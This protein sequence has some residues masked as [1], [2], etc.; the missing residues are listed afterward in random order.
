M[1]RESLHGGQERSQS[2][3]LPH[4]SLVQKNAVIAQY[5]LSAKF[6]LPHPAKAQGPYH[7][8]LVADRRRRA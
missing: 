4:E 1:A 6:R 8:A 5:R 2:Q 3:P 7:L